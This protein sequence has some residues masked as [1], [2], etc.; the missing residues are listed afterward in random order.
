MCKESEPRKLLQ[1]CTTD[2]KYKH[3][4]SIIFDER[5]IKGT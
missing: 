2:A 5:I 4:C 3:E 1:N